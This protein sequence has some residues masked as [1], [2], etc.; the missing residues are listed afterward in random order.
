MPQRT[1]AERSA[2]DDS[3]AIFASLDFHSCDVVREAAQRQV[4]SGTQGVDHPD[5]KLQGV[6]DG[7]GR[8][9]IFI[10]LDATQ[11]LLASIAQLKLSLEVDTVP[12]SALR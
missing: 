12:D 11:N 2:S 4:L 10:K 5:F 9:A 8:A 6:K 7:S 1:A 3:Y